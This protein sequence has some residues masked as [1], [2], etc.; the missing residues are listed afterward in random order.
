MESGATGEKD[1]RMFVSLS[2]HVSPVFY[3]LDLISAK[4]FCGQ[5][6]LLD[7]NILLVGVDKNDRH[8]PCLCSGH[9]PINYYAWRQ[10][11][12]LSLLH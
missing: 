7:P 2:L 9:A 4:Q 12:V 5:Q 8:T 10:V 6:G 3:F 1:I 11:M